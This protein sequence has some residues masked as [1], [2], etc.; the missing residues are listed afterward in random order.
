MQ[1]L[2]IFSKMR[3]KQRTDEVE[4]EEYG[5]K[6]C[7]IIGAVALAICLVATS[8]CFIPQ[9]AQAKEITSF[10][11]VKK[12]A[13][14]EVKGG[15]VV[16]VD[17]DYD[18][19]KLVYEVELSKG[20]KEYNLAYR[21]S[22]SK[23]ISYEWEIYPWH[24]SRGKGKLITVNKA[25]K[26]AEKQVKGAAIT[27]IMKKYSDGIDVYRVKMKSS[28][29]KYELK[30][31]ARTGKVLEYEWELVTKAGKKYIGEE[32]AVSI[33]LKKVGSGTV[34]KV[35]FDYDDGIPVYEVDI[36]KDDFEYE[37]EIHALTGKILNFEVEHMYD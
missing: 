17:R 16:K 25:K 5:M 32:K 20:K 26:L 27:S 7:K 37:V 1:L 10:S 12:L 34:V 29:K 28:K 23:L 19:G 2:A 3:W 6:R 22:D 9:T 14:K 13:K 11:Q 21:A 31:H 24:V 18:N 35:D 30:L 15:T 33:A 4:E 36:I 8:V